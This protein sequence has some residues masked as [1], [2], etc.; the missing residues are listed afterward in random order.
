MW[1]KIKKVLKNVLVGI[2]WLV[3]IVAPFAAGIAAKEDVNT[4]FVQIVGWITMS[5]V[6][7]LSAAVLWLKSKG[8]LSAKSDKEEK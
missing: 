1:T 8:R 4:V 6:A 3:G 2:A 7:V 5:E